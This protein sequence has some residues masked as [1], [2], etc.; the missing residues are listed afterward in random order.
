MAN[1]QGVS[2]DG[3]MGVAAEARIEHSSSRPLSW[4]GSDTFPRKFDVD[5]RGSSDGSRTN[6]RQETWPAAT[7]RWK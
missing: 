6:L 7:L 4:F 2:G 3:T 1:I 5:R